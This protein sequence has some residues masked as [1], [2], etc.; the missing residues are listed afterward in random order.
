MYRQQV[1]TGRHPLVLAA[2]SSGTCLE[3]EALLPQHCTFNTSVQ[4]A[5]LHMALFLQLLAQL[6]P[7]QRAPA[8][9]AAL[10]GRVPDEDLPVVGRLS[11][12]NFK[13]ALCRPCQMFECCY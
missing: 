8:T 12:L 13:P 7:L 9:A 6:R 10:S 5:S 2:G 11:I 3:Q 1:D 4:P